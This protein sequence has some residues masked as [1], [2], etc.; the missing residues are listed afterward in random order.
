MCMISVNEIVLSL[1]CIWQDFKSLL[2]KGGDPNEVE[3]ATKASLLHWAA[4]K[5]CTDAVKLL[6]KFKANTDIKD[7]CGS[8]PLMRACKKGHID[9]ATILLDRWVKMWGFHT[10]TVCRCY[11]LLFTVEWR[12]MRKQLMEEHHCMKLRLLVTVRWSSCWY[13]RRQMF[14]P[15]MTVDLHHINLP[16]GR[17]T[18]M[19]AVK[20]LSIYLFI[21]G[22]YL[23]FTGD[24]NFAAVHSN[25]CSPIWSTWFH[26]SFK[27]SDYH[28]S[29]ISGQQTD[30]WLKRLQCEDIMISAVSD[31]TYFVTSQWSSLVAIMY[32]FQCT[33]QWTSRCPKVSQSPILCWQ[34]M[35][36]V[37]IW[38]LDQP[39]CKYLT[40]RRSHKPWMEMCVQT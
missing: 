18:K 2:E 7:D 21:C 24:G 36:G 27:L 17:D 13:K 26:Q 31:C 11:I 30:L 39:Q 3:P 10:R 34:W 38:L 9:V 1:L 33:I 16:S 15:E 28:Y 6:I 40:Q 35:F 32:R 8:T 12:W 5:G 20:L 37:T 22:I 4:E 23:Q 25:S 19:Y 14:S 29:S